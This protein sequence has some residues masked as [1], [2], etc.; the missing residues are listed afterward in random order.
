MRKRDTPSCET[1]QALFIF[2][3]DFLMKFYYFT[4][5]HSLSLTTIRN[6]LQG[7]KENEQSRDSEEKYWRKT[8]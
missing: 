3:F 2:Q 7:R 4:L 1:P 8:F 5:I 6:A